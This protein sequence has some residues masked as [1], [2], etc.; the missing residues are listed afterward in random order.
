MAAL[1]TDGASALWVSL[2]TAASMSTTLVL[3]C[4]TPFPSLAALAAG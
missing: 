3:A 2:L 1:R 4:A